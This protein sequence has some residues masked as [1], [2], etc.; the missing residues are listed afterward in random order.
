MSG[1]FEMLLAKY[2]QSVKLC[3]HEGET[4]TIRVFLQPVTER[5]E[6]WRQT[7][8]SPMGTVRK[9]RF[10]CLTGVDAPLEH[11][12]DG[13]LEWRELRLK[14]SAVQPIY[15]GGTISHW[16]AILAAED[17]GEGETYGGTG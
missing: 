5:R 13:Y 11:L 2:G 15:I 16:W 12:E 3:R 14:V 9:D 4:E 1:T 7:E 6:T 8:P 17:P 10:L